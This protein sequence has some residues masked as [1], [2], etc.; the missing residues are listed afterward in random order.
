M[1][2]TADLM[3]EWFTDV[4]PSI[5]EQDHAYDDALDLAHDHGV[6]CGAAAERARILAI[7]DELSDT[8]ALGFEWDAVSV[9]QLRRRIIDGEGSE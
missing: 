7:V 1:S 2:E 5:M 8:T 4:R 3:G 9:K 6:K